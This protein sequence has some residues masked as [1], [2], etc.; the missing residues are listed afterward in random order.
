[1]LISQQYQKD[2]S[3]R[4]HYSATKSISEHHNGS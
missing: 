3:K 1:M 2:Y 4:P